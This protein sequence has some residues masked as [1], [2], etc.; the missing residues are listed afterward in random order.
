[1]AI[2]K[3][4]RPKEPRDQGII[5]IGNW[6]LNGT[7]KNEIEIANRCRVLVRWSL[8]VSVAV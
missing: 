1:M 4:K 8:V 2:P 3:R 5:V 6:A 7:V